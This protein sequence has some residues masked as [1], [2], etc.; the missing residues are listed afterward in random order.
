MGGTSQEMSSHLEDDVAWAFEDPPFSDPDAPMGHTSFKFMNGS[1][2]VFGHVW[3][4][5]GPARKGCV[6]MSPQTFG[7]DS[8][9]SVILPLLRCGINVLSFIPRGMWDRS[10]ATYTMYSAVDDLHALIGYVRSNDYGPET[11]MA[12]FRSRFDPDRIVLFGHSGGGGNVS[13]AAC[14]ESDYV[15]HAAATAPAN[16]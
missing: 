8:L 6:I 3:V 11:P 10:Q 9:E 1:E 7:G 12:N 2:P 13:F 5:Q 16:M 15:N 4:A 14:A